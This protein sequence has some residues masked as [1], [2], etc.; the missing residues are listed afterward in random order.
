MH[1]IKYINSDYV[2]ASTYGVPFFKPHLILA[3]LEDYYND[4]C[5]ANKLT[6]EQ[7]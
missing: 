1:W 2:K 4:F 7:Q 3:T 5:K 6:V